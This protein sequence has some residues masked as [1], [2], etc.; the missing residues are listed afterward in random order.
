MLKLVLRRVAWS[1]PLALV[2]SVVSFLLVALLPG[3]AARS[4][5]GPN[6]TQAQLDQARQQLGLD[7]PLWVQYGRWLSGALPGDLGSPL[8]NRQPVVE[9]LNQRL[10][11]SLSLIIGA[12]L[13]ATTIGVLLGVRGARR[14]AIGRL[15]KAGSIIGLALPDF[16]LGLVLVVFF[17]V[18]LS[19]FPPTGYVALGADPAGWSRSL[20]LPVATLTVPA[21]AVIARQTREAV[22]A[23][24]DR[25]FVRT[26]RAAGV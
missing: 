9:Q 13:V 5:L 21:T 15:V 14:G 7:Q 3:D 26:L 10:A 22:S 16:W 6:A 20:G 2:A 23:A 4:L 25:S 17:A 18:R 1:V 11:P 19:L 24:L 8:I 12:V